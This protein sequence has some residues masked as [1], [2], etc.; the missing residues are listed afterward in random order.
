[1]KTYRISYKVGYMRVDTQYVAQCPILA[2]QQ[3][4]HDMI[5]STYYDY[6][7]VKDV[8]ILEV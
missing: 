4:C 5:C 6:E 8:L 7:S 3:F 2:L 1:M